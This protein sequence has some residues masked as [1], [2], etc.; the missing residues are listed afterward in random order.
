MRRSGFHSL[1][2]ARTCH[3]RCAR[4]CAISHSC[5]LMLTPSLVLYSSFS[6]STSLG[7]SPILLRLS[8]FLLASLCLSLPPSPPLSFNLCSI[9][10]RKECSVGY[11]TRT[12]ILL[13][14]S[15][16]SIHTSST[17][18]SLIVFTD[19]SALLSL[20]FIDQHT[21]ARFDCYSTRIN[22]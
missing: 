19:L 2:K 6:F 17:F 4:W 14:K 10:S 18:H 12:F 7:F 1:K 9:P 16:H 5:S 20:S 22:S 3:W 13:S 21:P 15:Y 11:N 8:L